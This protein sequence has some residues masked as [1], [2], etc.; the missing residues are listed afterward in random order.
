MR[1]HEGLLWE[2]VLGDG[3]RDHRVEEDVNRAR[4]G[5]D[6]GLSDGYERRPQIVLTWGRSER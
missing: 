5:G 4:C 3:E 1:W 2:R 6:E